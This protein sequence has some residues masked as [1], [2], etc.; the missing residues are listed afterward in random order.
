[1]NW[2][3]VFAGLQILVCVCFVALALCC[4]R[5]SR[6]Y[7]EARERAFESLRAAREAWEHN[8]QLLHEAELA[9]KRLRKLQGEGE[10]WK[11]ES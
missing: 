7:E 2:D 8:I 5:M 6:F 10:E 9:C 11:R 1:M 3:W 4:A